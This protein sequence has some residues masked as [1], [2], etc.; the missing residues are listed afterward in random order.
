MTGSQLVVS[1]TPPPP[2]ATLEEVFFWGGE[3]MLVFNHI[4]TDTRSVVD[5]LQ[6]N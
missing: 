4:S 5:Y 3:E 6:S 1:P 2:P